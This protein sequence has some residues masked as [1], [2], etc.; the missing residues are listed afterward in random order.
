MTGCKQILLRRN[1]EFYFVGAAILLG[2]IGHVLW[3]FVGG[4]P[5]E[6]HPDYFFAKAAFYLSL[7][8]LLGFALMG[9]LLWSVWRDDQKMGLMASI[10]WLLLY[11]F[12]LS[13]FLGISHHPVGL[14][15]WMLPLLM[16]GSA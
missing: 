2:L 3:W 7:I 5:E 16:I 6:G 13:I 1:R 9:L 4:I 10:L 11:L 14:T 15:V 12:L 8:E